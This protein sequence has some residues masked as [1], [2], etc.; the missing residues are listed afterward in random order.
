MDAPEIAPGYPVGE[1]LRPLWE[2][3]WSVLEQG[4]APGAKLANDPGI[5][6]TGTPLACRPGTV[7]TLLQSGHRYGLLERKYVD[8]SSSPGA[9]RRRYAIYSIKVQ[10]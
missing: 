3:L 2:R 7:V 1:R 6:A 5:L 10:S 4:E 8:W 9:P